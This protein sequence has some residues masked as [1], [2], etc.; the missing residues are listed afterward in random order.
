MKNDSYPLMAERAELTDQSPEE[1]VAEILQLKSELEKSKER[2]EDAGKAFQAE[3]DKLKNIFEAIQDGIYIVNWEGD[4]EY[5]NPVLEKQFGPYQGRKCYAYFHGRNEICPWCKNAN[6]HAGKTVQ[7]EWTSPSG[8]TFDLLDTPLKNLDGTISK[9]ELFRDISDRKK[10]EAELQKAHDTLEER[11]EERTV[12][13]KQRERELRE[14]NQELQRLDK[15]KD[16]FLANTSHELR[17][18]INGIIGIAESLIEGATGELDKRTNANL[19]MIAT[20]GK[21]LSSL[22]NDILDFSKLKHQGIGLQLKPLELRSIIDMVLALS[23]PLI[24]QKE[25]YFVNT[26]EFDLPAVFADENRLQQILHNLIGNAIKFTEQGHITISAQAINEQ[27][28]QITISDNGIGIP[29]DKLDRI[30]KS[31]EQAEGSTSREYGGTGLGLAVTKQLVQLHGG[32][33]RV[34]STP[35]VGSK[36]RF[37][38]PISDE[39]VSEHSSV[40]TSPLSKVQSASKIEVDTLQPSLTKSQTITPNGFNILIVDDESVNLQVLSNY[41]SLQ[42]YGIIQASSGEEA[43]ALIEEGLKPDAILLDVMMPRMTGYEVTQ[44]L[45]KKWQADQLPIV[46]L[47]AKN[48]VEDLVTGFGVGANDYITKPFSKDELM[49]RIQTHIRISQLKAESLQLEIET[50]AA[51]VASQAKSDFLSNMSHELRTPLN[52]ILGYAQIL[53]RGKNLEESQV[54][55][56]NTIYQSGNHLLTLI[57]DILDLS[58]IEARKLEL[59]PDTL[60][61]SNF[62]E[63]LSGI[64]RMRAEQKNVYF[65][66]EA[67]GEL[68]TGI[69]A[70]EKRLRQV[71]INLLG[72]AIK[73]TD[74]GQVTLRVSIANEMTDNQA[75]I[76]FEVEDS[77][78]GMT[79]EQ[80]DKIFLPFEQV[81]DT[82]RRAAGTGLGLAISRQL[83]ELMGSEILVSSEFGKGSHFWFEIALTK[84]NVKEEAMQKTLQVIG[85][86]GKRRTI[87]IVDDNPQN[88]KILLSLL[89]LLDFNVVEAS[90]GQ[91]SVA[92][93]KEIQPDMIFM[94]L[95]MPVMT[96]FEAVQIL[97]QMPEFKNTP[98][99]ANSASVFEAA[100]EKSRIA[101]CNAFLPNPSKRRN[102]LAYWLNISNWNG[103]T[104][105]SG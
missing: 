3:K 58:K 85:Y 21:R 41:L 79:E 74:K 102:S 1:L 11:V 40:I 16:E 91:E 53:R 2:H 38:L 80:L 76:R 71:L 30:F 72:N 66:Y 57:N 24:A 22:V 5:A 96:G 13:L 47:T 68:P 14:M 100:Q 78:V 64:I 105:R 90:N 70:D 33:I 84:V 99:I 36:F 65:S 60:H 54:S 39:L 83:V 56:L 94:D 88:L 10:T 95:V 20:S 18:P 97:R 51:K 104:K 19:A 44:K 82:K 59:Y 15:L 48:Q 63:S 7:W 23:Q 12:E 4:I 42:N 45:R 75:L 52:G 81:G 27:Q 17:T 77:G 87:L 8:R 49:A 86:H 67:V 69:K 34:E 61:F 73:F 101:G 28:V 31:F 35:K 89:K 43:L 29:A 92:L 32:E 50:E 98:I 37:T 9:L 26:V 25:L 6:V 55:G 93:A 46:L 62:I 103:F